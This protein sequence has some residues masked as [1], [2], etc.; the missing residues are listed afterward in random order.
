MH[1]IVFEVPG[2]GLPIRSFGLM[3]AGGF[4]LGMWIM[5]QLVRRY[6]SDPDAELVKYSAVQVWILVGVILGARLMYVIVEIARGSETG[7][8]YLDDPLSIL[9]VWKGG[10]VM[11]GGLFGGLLA[12]VIKARAER[13]NV[14]QGLDLGLTAGFFGLAVGR[15]GCLLVGDDYGK[16]VPEAYAHLPFPI[17]LR[18]PEVLPEGSLFG[19]ENAGELLWATQV[20][21]AANALLLGLLGLLLLRRAHRD[22]SVAAALVLAYSVGRFAIEAFR[23]DELRGMWFDGRL[24]TSQLVSIAVFLVCLFLWSRLRRDP[25]PARTP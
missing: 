17:T 19:E 8:E 12:G 22:G 3:V 16:V 25:L 6:G 5:N 13:V 21:M 1:P 18:V 9:F 10:L 15:I 23:G 11:F 2:L 4:L 14:R 7:R 24:S 20:W